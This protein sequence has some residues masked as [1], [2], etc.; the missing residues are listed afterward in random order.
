MKQGEAL[1]RNLQKIWFEK[2]C[3]F[4]CACRSC[5]R[6]EINNQEILFSIN[7]LIN[8][9]DSQIDHHIYGPAWMEGK[10]GRKENGEGNGRENIFPCL[11]GEKTGE[12]GK[13]GRKIMWVP[14]PIFLPSFPSPYGKILSHQNLFSHFLPLVERTHS[15]LFYSFS[16]QINSLLLLIFSPST[17]SQ[18]FISPFLLRCLPI[19]DIIF[20]LIHTH[21]LVSSR[22][23]SL[24]RF[25]L[26]LFSFAHILFFLGLLF[27]PLLS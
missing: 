3:M 26:F 2:S 19:V 22:K 18:S 21:A 27:L 23:M 7:Q 16:S 5:N 8:R 25:F 6:V 12:E 1:C 9:L 24:L 11:I 14:C 4:K 10:C 20:F 15:R 13:Q 17:V